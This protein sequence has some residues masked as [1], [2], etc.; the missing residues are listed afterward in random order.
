MH[1]PYKPLLYTSA[2]IFCIRC[3]VRSQKKE[4]M[5]RA[6][7]VSF[8]H[9]VCA[10]II[11][12]NNIV[13]RPLNVYNP[14]WS[15]CKDAFGVHLMQKLSYSKICI[16]DHYL[17]TRRQHMPVARSVGTDVALHPTLPSKCTR[18]NVSIFFTQLDALRLY[19]DHPREKPFHFLTPRYWACTVY[20]R[21]VRLHATM[22]RLVGVWRRSIARAVGQ[23]SFRIALAI[24][25]CHKSIGLHNAA[26]TDLENWQGE[27]SGFFK[28]FRNNFKR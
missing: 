24:L 11:S 16:K 10:P 13:K 15:S 20:I 9:T 18:G 4:I 22:R 2:S 23:L 19:N 8:M 26:L 5:S 14:R 17:I 27:T 3:T 12:R 21:R 25:G 1:Y 7:V 6:L 28:T